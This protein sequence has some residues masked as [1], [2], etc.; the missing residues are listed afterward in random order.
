MK[1]AALSFYIPNKHFFSLVVL[2]C[3]YF[4]ATNG[5]N[6][7]LVD[8]D[9]NINIAKK[10]II[11]NPKRAAKL[12]ATSLNI[13]E[14]ENYLLGKRTS[15]LGLGAIDYYKGNYENSI[16]YYKKAL[17]VSKEIN[18]PDKIASCLV[19]IAVS[20]SKKGNYVLAMDDYLEALSYFK[21]DTTSI[22]NTYQ[23]IS[24]IHTELDQHN[25][26]TANLINA[27]SLSKKIKNNHLIAYNYIFLGKN[28]LA[29]GDLDKAYEYLIISKKYIVPTSSILLKVYFNENLSEYYLLLGRY[30]ESLEYG[31][32]MYQLVKNNNLESEKPRITLLMGNVHFKLNNI[33]EA[34]KFYLKS[35]ELS[36][37][38]N[39]KEIEAQ[40]NLK[41]YAIFCQENNSYNALKHIENYLQ[42]IDTLK[43]EKNVKIISN[44]RVKFD[45]EKKD[46]EINLQNLKIQK[47]E[48]LILKKQRET[49]IFVIIIA[50]ILLSLLFILL[51]Y[52]NK[53]RLRQQEIKTLKAGSEVTK[54]DALIEGEEKERK[55]LAQDLH[56]GINGDLSALKFQ[57]LSINNITS[58]DEIPEKIAKINNYLDASIEQVRSIS[59]NLAPPALHDYSLPQIIQNYCAT[60]SSSCSTDID[61][62]FFGEE[63]FNLK[64]DIEISIYR[65]LQELINNMVK[66]SKATNALVQIN[67]HENKLYITVE[68]NGKG[69]DTNKTNTGIGLQNIVSRINFLKGNLDTFSDHNGTT[70]TID[71]CIKKYYI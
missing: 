18:D 67:H 3:F 10:N 71:I 66:H 63:K 21:K 32:K 53:Q 8:I 9:E 26:A 59:H 13:S 69:F 52:K 28:Y 48:T 57:I 33:N 17:H 55:R 24:K 60:I 56:D 12:F 15:Y 40:T 39:N 35:L 44:L 62:Q 46:N 51:F 20:N 49:L 58:I 31:N 42:L 4:L 2:F 7:K 5:Q 70:F 34:K 36:K 47:Q 43:S 27:I 16:S 23:S 29:L 64:K 22:I 11:S 41:L 6:K 25:E 1:K 45:S 61:F 38:T 65:I 54:R 19:N 50:S 37:N 30:K 14:K 68:D